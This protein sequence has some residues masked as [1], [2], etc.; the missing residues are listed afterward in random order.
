MGK[1]ED[2]IERLIASTRGGG[3]GDPD[4]LQ[5]DLR[6]MEYV[7]VATCNHNRSGMHSS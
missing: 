1:L 4:A 6:E 3:F 5:G 2:E 7:S